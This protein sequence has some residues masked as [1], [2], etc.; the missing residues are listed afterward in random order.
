MKRLKENMP[1]YSLQHIIKERYPRFVDALNDL[2]DAL[3]LTALFNILPKHEMHQIS[4]EMTANCK[5]LTR[6]FYLY[7]AVS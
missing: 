5:R 2:D 1:Q 3:S 4:S 7:L 6:E